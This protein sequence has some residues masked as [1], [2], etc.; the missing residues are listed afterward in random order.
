MSGVWAPER[1][2]LTVGLLLTV[3]LV[4]FESLSVATIMPIVGRELDGLAL[5]GWVF[6][7]FFLGDLVGIV[8]AGAQADR[9]SLVTPFV[10]GLGLF[11]V[12]LIIDGLA[13]SMAALVVGRATQGLGAGAV[14]TVAYVAIGRRYPD[15]IRPVMFANLSTAWVVPGLVGPAVAGLVADHLSWRFV[16]LGLVPL[17]VIGLVITA[18]ALRDPVAAAVQPR[19]EPAPEPLRGADTVRQRILPAIRVAVGAA[20]LL[21]GLTTRD[22]LSIA[23]AVVGVAI[24]LPA[25]VRLVPRGTL[26]AARGLPTVIL[27]R[28][29]ATFAMFGAEAFLPLTLVSLRGAS[30]TEAGL[31][32]TAATLTW[33]AG[34]WIQARLMASWGALRL[35]RVG[36]I[37]VTI[38]VAGVATV[39]LPFVPV[40]V[41][42]IAWGL[43]G[44][45][46]GLAYSPISL[47]VLRDAPLGEEGT[48]TA[49]MQL[50][51]VLGTALGT[52]LGGAIVAAGIAL[53]I[54]PQVYLGLAFGISTAVAALGV[55]LTPR[56]RPVPAS[57]AGRA[58]LP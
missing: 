38:G 42:V 52:G 31:A 47:T 20:L 2:A 34:S 35:I 57:P 10:A 13:P 26:R 49:A 17:V 21:G 58:A 22:L 50:C 40:E 51:D 43:T 24:G 48:A 25:L 46:M 11:A 19:A 33:T 15:A 18:P 28:G 27:I 3:T 30:A 41:A 32:L 14:P 36:L 4:A 9:G 39:L 56:M 7:A 29:V 37:A 12:G 54:E 45:G 44:L 8:A 6:S 53:L 1:R 23:L 16:F 5:Y 55:A